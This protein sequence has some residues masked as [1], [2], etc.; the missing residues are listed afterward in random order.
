[1]FIANE[2]G[3]DGINSMLVVSGFF[4]VILIGIFI[5]VIMQLLLLL[6][7]N[8]SAEDFIQQILCSP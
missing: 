8:G 7:F 6:L 5:I 4:L 1:M 2:D 3:E